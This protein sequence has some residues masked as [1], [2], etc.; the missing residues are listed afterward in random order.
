MLK[1]A[2]AIIQDQEKMLICQ[3][4]PGKPLALLWEFPG[5]KVE[6]EESF[7]ECIVRECLEELG[8]EVKVETVFAEYVY[9]YPEQAIHFVFFGCQI[10]KGIPQAKEN[11]NFVWV[12][13]SELEKYP[14]CPADQ[15]VIQKLSQT[16]F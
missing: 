12:K 14:F 13:K 6:P 7:S 8:I 11:Q 3:R 16:D 5:G 4:P 9:H 2:A 1:V 15:E 10:Q